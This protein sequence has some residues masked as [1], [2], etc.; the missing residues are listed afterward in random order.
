M[1]LKLNTTKSMRKPKGLVKCGLCTG[2]FYKGIRFSVMLQ[3]FVCKDCVP[4]LRKV[5]PWD[6]VFH[7]GC[8]TFP[9]CDI[10]GCGK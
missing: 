2:L 1:E 4:D 5:S 6:D 7:L 8:P 10:I 9:N 3:D